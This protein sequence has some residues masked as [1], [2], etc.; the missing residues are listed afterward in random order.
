MLQSDRS[1]WKFFLL[2]IVTC[3]IYEIVFL[4]NM[5]K[6]LNKLGEG[7]GKESPNAIV[8]L[9]L[10]IVTCS[11]YGFIWYY[12]QGNRLQDILKAQGVDCKE[13]GTTY[14]LWTLIPY[15]GHLIT[16]YLFIGNMNTACG[17]Y[18]ARRA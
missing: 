2:S 4:W 11:V 5:I 12:K 1:F 14:V 6:D 13:S 3:G 9:L 17:N 8:M 10:T 7:D 16:M 15:V 18:N